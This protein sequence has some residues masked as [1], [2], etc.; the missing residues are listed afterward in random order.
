VIAEA[1]E[2]D[3]GGICPSITPEEGTTRRDMIIKSNRGI[4]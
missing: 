4:P 1:Y 3:E 2:E